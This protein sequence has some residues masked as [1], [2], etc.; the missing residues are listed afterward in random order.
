MTEKKNRKNASEVIAKERKDDISLYR[1]IIL[2]L[3]G[4]IGFPLIGS[5]KK[6]PKETLKNATP[7]LFMAGCIFIAT[8]VFL[9]IYVRAVRKKDESGKLVTSLGIG[10]MIAVVGTVLALY[11]FFDDASEKFQVAFIMVILLGCVYNLYTR[12]F[13]DVS[14]AICL[15]MFFLYFINI[16]PF[17]YLELFL[18]YFCRTMIFPLVL[19]GIILAVLK[20]F[21]IKTGKKLSR[22]IPE[23]RF[24]AVLSAIVWCSSAVAAAFLMAFSA[25][26]AFILAYFIVLFIVL[27]IICT[28]KLL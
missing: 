27:G 11:P 19:C 18:R 10:G 12:G 6:I 3:E 24:Y 28:I 25:G 20:I 22:L 15:S 4:M 5:L 2:F 8:A 16:T 26:Y 13:F 7:Y 1:I 21:G 9:P 23:S 17:T 14:I